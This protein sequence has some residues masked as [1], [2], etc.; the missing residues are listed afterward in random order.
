MH[1]YNK[2]NLLVDNQETEF[3]I[4][5][6]L[7]EGGVGEVLLAR[8]N[9]L[10]RNVAFKFVKAGMMDNPEVVK[11]FL[12]EASVMAQLDH[13]AII[14]IYRVSTIEDGRI[15]YSM[16][17]IDG[18]T[19]AELIREARQQID[20]RGKI[21]STHEL[22]TL[23]E[24]FVKVCDAIHY[25]HSKDIVHRDLKPSNIM[26]GPYNE[27]YVLDWGIAKA[28][29]EVS[30]MHALAEELSMD[31][32]DF[33][34][35]TQVGTIL[36]TPRYMSPEQAMG[37]H[38]ILDG[39][40]DQF[41]LGLI[42]FEITSFS[43][44]FRGNSWEE[45]QAKV[46][47]AQ[48]EPIVHHNPNQT[49]P[50]ELRAIIRKATQKDPKDRYA[51]VAHFA[52]DIRRY[53][54]GE[55][56]S[57][58]KDTLPQKMMRWIA[59]HKK[60][61]LGTFVSLISLSLL[62]AAWSLYQKQQEHLQAQA[63]QLHMGEILTK[64]AG[65]A[66][67]I[68]R[69]F[70]QFEFMLGNLAG[71]A[72]QLMQYGQEQPDRFYTSED[73]STDKGAPDLVMSKA[74]GIPISVGWPAVKIA[75]NAIDSEAEKT[76]R[77]LIPL[78]RTF[79]QI[80]RASLGLEDS[81]LKAFETELIETGSPMVWAYVGTESGVHM[82][83][84][85][86]SGYPAE[87]DPR[88]RPWYVN[89]LSTKGVQWLPPYVDIGGRGLM[90]A[91]TMQLHDKQGGLLGVAGVEMSLENLRDMLS[92]VNNN[93]LSTTYL[94]DSEGH[95]IT[96]SV[97]AVAKFS[98]GT[99]I[100]KQNE[101]PIYQQAEIVQRLKRGET[102]HEMVAEPEGKKLIVFYHIDSVGWY[103]VVESPFSV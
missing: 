25:A 90:L 37:Q 43:P 46:V 95:I 48:L 41:S 68:E 60:K 51:S 15:G 86:K 75:P 6:A 98:V 102:G 28:G 11:R 21:S 18:R 61:A 63:D 69:Q 34:E 72:T 26:I 71:S 76:V 45:L 56:V 91:S 99:L 22:S 9:P 38:D 84:P 36:G 82:A 58:H 5:G 97:D 33:S 55:A 12:I 74:Y 101:L 66:Q 78:R 57:V 96:S 35:R 94:L 59:Q 89:S 24:H 79:Q 10:H 40:S 14:P 52:S 7:G 81:P 54:K 92:V 64:V 19:L 42:L 103:L 44:A 88:V 67:A 27:V 53:L 17:P 13:P 2:N 62:V 3:C 100:N 93:V 70:L 4:L 77:K 49:V 16:K 30:E 87:Y 73:N 23:L 39:R 31:P 83:Y 29:K 20:F 85:G 32:T 80:F 1:Q 65:K 50:V 8:E 47:H